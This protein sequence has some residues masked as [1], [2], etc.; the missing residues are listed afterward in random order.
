MQWIDLPRCPE[1]DLGDLERAYFKWVPRLTVDGVR[2][3]WSDQGLF[4]A[5][6]P[7]GWPRLIRMDPAQDEPG[8]RVRAIIGGFLAGR[9]GAIEFELR[10]FPAGRRL[11]VAVRGLRPRLP[12]WLYLRLQSR[13]HVRSTFAFL[14]QMAWAVSADVQSTCAPQARALIVSSDDP[15]AQR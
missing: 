9:G 6:E 2:P 12:A 4:L 10:P 11:V 3:H 8:L 7:F 13:M 15:H 5:P 1:L 14:R